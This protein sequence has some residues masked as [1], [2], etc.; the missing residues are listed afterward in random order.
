MLWKYEGKTN[1]DQYL[2]W[3]NSFD[4]VSEI[5]FV[6]LTLNKISKIDYQSS[7]I[8]PTQK[9]FIRILVEDKSC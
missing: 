4:E 1:E 5:T 7:L 9:T 2:R 6:F 8:Y 3:F